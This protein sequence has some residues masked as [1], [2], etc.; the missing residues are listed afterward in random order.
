MALPTGF[1]PNKMS[2]RSVTP[3]IEI[4]RNYSTSTSYSSWG[5]RRESLWSRFNNAVAK[6]GNW[7]ADHVD[8]AIGICC[9]LALVGIVITGLVY[10]IGTWVNEGFGWALLVAVGAIIGGYICF[11]LS[12][13]VVNIVI[14]IVMYG[15]RFLFW[16]GWTLLISLVITAGA[17]LWAANYT[18]SY[19]PRASAPTETA[20]PATQTFQC[21]ADVLNI[22]TSPNTYSNVIGTLKKGQQVKVYET[23]NGFARISY[24]GQTGY[25]SL[26]YLNRI[27]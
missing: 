23:T 1:D 8:N 21:T 7:F 22:R 16:N 9:G 18:P 10:V 26:K 6:L 11:G 25:V 12:W 19:S 17:W 2:F 20:T 3:V 5:S 4:P 13:Y 15:F 24:N 27:N 14:N